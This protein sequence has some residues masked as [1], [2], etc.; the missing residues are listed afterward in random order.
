MK[1]IVYLAAV[2][3]TVIA[4][5]CTFGN[6]TGGDSADSTLAVVKS[7]PVG[8]SVKEAQKAYRVNMDG[9]EWY[10]TLSAVAQWPESVGEHDITVLQDSLVRAAFGHPGDITAAIAAY[11]ND[12]KAQGIDETPT[13]VDFNVVTD[14]MAEVRSMYAEMDMRLVGLTERLITYSVSTESY[15]GGPHPYGATRFMTY[16]LATQRVITPELLFTHPDSPELLNVIRENMAAQMG[17]TTE[18]LNSMLINDL[19]VTDNVSI[20]DGALQFHYNQYDVLPYSDGEINVMVQPFE[21]SSMLT[22]AAAE[23]LDE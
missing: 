15:M 17:V 11:V 5:G 16:D 7:V 6:S 9:E 18:L 19:Y 12:V 10:L 13:E 3:V 8:L 22:E 1:R 21:V 14:S 23:L 4:T 2:V 20:V